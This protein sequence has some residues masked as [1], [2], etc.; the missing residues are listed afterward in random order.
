MQIRCQFCHMPFALGKEAVHQ[1]LDT[2]TEQ[3]LH[4][5]NVPCPHCRKTNR[6]SKTSLLRAAP[7]WVKKEP[8]QPEGTET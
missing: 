7:G 8:A 6:I 1:A 2:M 3:A 4:H 5:Y